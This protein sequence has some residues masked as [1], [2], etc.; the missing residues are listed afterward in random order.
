MWGYV[1]SNINNTSTVF[2]A[3]IDVI[4]P[5]EFRKFRSI[6]LTTNYCSKKRHYVLEFRNNF[7][8]AFNGPITFAR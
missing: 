1:G 3:E 8:I 4:I 7:A 2:F 6:D 5:R